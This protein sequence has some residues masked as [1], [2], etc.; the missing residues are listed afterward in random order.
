MIL[1]SDRVSKKY[2]HSIK[3]YQ[4]SKIKFQNLN[5]QGKKNLMNV[6]LKISITDNSPEKETTHM[7]MN[8]FNELL[9]PESNKLMKMYKTPVF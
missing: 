9:K 3:K 8:K 7:W 2:R 1:Q 5:V 4:I 6:S